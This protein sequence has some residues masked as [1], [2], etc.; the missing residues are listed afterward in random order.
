MGGFTLAGVSYTLGGVAST[1]YNRIS[2][3]TVF[4]GLAILDPGFTIIGG[5]GGSITLGIVIDLL[6]SVANSNMTF[7]ISSPT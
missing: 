1:L 4:G 5:G 2:N 3:R 7:F 6:K